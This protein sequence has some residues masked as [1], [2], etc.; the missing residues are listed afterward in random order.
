MG[1]EASTATDPAQAGHDQVTARAVRFPCRAAARGALTRCGAQAS[2]KHGVLPQSLLVCGSMRGCDGFTGF[3]G[4]QGRRQE[5][6]I[7]CMRR[8]LPRRPSCAS[9]LALTLCA[10]RSHP[11]LARGASRGASLGTTRGAG[12]PPAPAAA[13]A[14]AVGQRAGTAVT[15]ELRRQGPARRLL[16][17]R[18]Q[19]R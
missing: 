15:T 14:S 2:G 5:A 4:K 13:V 11:D 10:L 7:S 16:V 18:E 19:V 6:G 17:Q 8:L 1:N 9:A 12:V 3:N